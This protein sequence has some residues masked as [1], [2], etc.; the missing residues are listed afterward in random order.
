MRTSTQLEAYWSEKN[1]QWESSHLSQQKFCEQH[2]LVYA[3]F[4]YWRGRLKQNK[5]VNGE[6]K[7]LKVLMPS[8]PPGSAIVTQAASRLEVVLPSGIKIYLK[9]D[10]DIAR[11]SVFIKL[12]GI[13]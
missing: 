6:Q 13:A 4:T 12:L 9:E 5:S 11:A 7:L 1:L 8:V 10:A 2:G 3:Q